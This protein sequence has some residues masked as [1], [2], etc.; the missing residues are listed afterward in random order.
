MTDPAFHEEWFCTESQN[1]LQALVKGAPPGLIV[2]FGAWEGRSSAA[3]ANAAYPRIVH[4]VD[5]WDGRGHPMSAEIASKRDIGAQ[6]QANMDA[7]TKGNVVGHKMGWREFLPEIKDPVALCFIDADH[8]YREVFDNVAAMVPLMVPGGVMCGDDAHHGP[9]QDALFEL[10]GTEDVAVLATVWMWQVPEDKA[11][12]DY[13]RLRA[14]STA[15]A[16]TQREFDVQLDRIARLYRHYCNAVSPQDMAASPATVAYLWQLCEAI[17]PDRVLD[18]GSGLSS[19]VLR[20]WQQERKPSVEIVSVDDNAEWLEK[21]R[22]FLTDNELSTDNLCTPD[23]VKGEF[24]LVFH[25]L[26]G[27]E[28]R[29]RA[30]EWAMRSL[31]PGGI[32]VLDDAHKHSYGATA[33]KE[34]VDLYSL[35]KLTRD[36]VGRWSVL[37]IKTGKKRSNLKAEYDR[38]AASPSDIFEHLPVFVDMVHQAN[39]QKVIEL[40]TRTGVSTIAWLYALE[41]TGGH[42]WSVDIDSKPAIGDYPHWTFI[43]GDDESDVVLSQLP[44]KVDILFLDTSHHYEHT[45]RELELYL[46]QVKPGGLIVCHDTELPMPEGAPPQDGPYPVKRAIQEFTAKHGL[47]WFNLP[48]CW[49]LGIIEVV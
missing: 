34:G 24:D 49:G 41:Q 17:N 27:G 16:P 2:E 5:P 10:L 26:A 30:A 40:G 29:D 19:A 45:K 43:Q 13:V 47:R 37:G 38:V 3:L 21:T 25:D 11:E 23:D 44:E 42:L 18:L 33:G 32:I 46:S 48:N 12:L 15:L 8:S 1:V 6:W 31:R 14:L 9:V 35:E 39:A 36:A 22:K 7:H 20:K 4:S 28:V